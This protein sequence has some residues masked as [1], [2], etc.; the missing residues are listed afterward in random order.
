MKN[1]VI[2]LVSILISGFTYQTNAQEDVKFKALYTYNFTNFIEW[3][4]TSGNFVVKVVGDIPELYKAD[5]ETKNVNG[6][7]ISVISVADPSAVGDCHI[8]YVPPAQSGVIAS[9]I[10]GLTGK[11]TLI[12]TDSSAFEE[13]VSINFV[14]NSN[15]LGIQISEN[16]IRN[17]GLKV[18]KQLLNMGENMDPQE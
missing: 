6:Q 3:P 18:N 13:G 1:I 5:L 15:N 10:S 14:M 8:L 4:A 17:Q 16:S 2:F 9:A 12:I 7:A 11:N